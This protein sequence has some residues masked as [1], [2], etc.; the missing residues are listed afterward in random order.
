M[1]TLPLAASPEDLRRAVWANLATAVGE[2]G[3]RFLLSLVLARLLA[4][5]ELG[6]YALGMAVY[7][8]AQL[9]RDAGLSV[10]LQ[11]EPVLTAERFSAVLG[12]GLAS[13]GLST[14]GLLAL[15]EPLAAGFGQGALAPVLQVLAL[16][17]PVSAFG[18][19]MAALHL[20]TLA[21]GAIARVSLIGLAVQAGVS[22]WACRQGAGALGLAWA[23]VAAALACGAVCARLRPPGL[24]WRPGLRGAGEVGRY[25]AGA[26]LPTALQQLH[27][28]LPDLLLGRLGGAHALGLF[29]RAQATVNLLQMVAARSL[30]F[31][32]LPV[33]S[34]RQAQGQALLP[35][36]RQA[37]ALL[38]GVGWPLLA[39]TVAYREPLVVGLYGEPWRDCAAAVPAL[40]LMAA[41]ALATQQLAPALAA[42]GHPAQAAAPLALMLVARVVGVGLGWDGGVVSFA[43]ALAAASVLA[44]P[45][46]ASLAGRHLGAG[47]RDALAALGGSALAALAVVLVPWT[48]APLAWLAA[49]R[50]SRHPLLAELLQAGRRFMT[51]RK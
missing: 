30:A 13:T 5:A 42:L 2:N 37:T 1:S 22:V 40:A 36:W 46:Q 39:L 25:A 3:L 24:R 38:T 4:P 18:S 48:L 23:Q 19:V 33:L 6:L 9:L 35:A 14:L 21:A 34:Q 45:L 28:L 41:L 43:A 8:V 29:S 50:A 47:P 49:L 11:R 17:L 32:V 51:S 44:L 26:W 15:A 16:L 10:Y 12:L 20:R 27:Q 7:G 31:G